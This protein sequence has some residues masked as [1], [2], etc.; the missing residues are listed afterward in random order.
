MPVTCGQPNPDSDTSGGAQGSK[1]N[2]S[3]RSADRTGATTY[4]IRLSM[5]RGPI[6]PN[7]SDDTNFD[8]QIF[9]PLP[10]EKQKNPDAQE[11]PGLS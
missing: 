8:N 3:S 1:A 6:F 7:F 10:F 4:F 5:L 11:H 9:G 2:L